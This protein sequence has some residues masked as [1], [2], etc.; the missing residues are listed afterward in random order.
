MICKKCKGSGKVITE[1]ETESGGIGWIQVTCPKCNGTGR[2]TQTN[3]EWF[4]KL[5]TKEK[6]RY[7]AKIKHESFWLGF[8]YA[9]DEEVFG[10]P[11]IEQD[12]IF[13]EK[14]LK[15]KHEETS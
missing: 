6:A 9:D 2:V 1:T 5:P 15:E 4:D 3:E 14:W 10:Q 13:F 12:T 8:E 7:F 11:N